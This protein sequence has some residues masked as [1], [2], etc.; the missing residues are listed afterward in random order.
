MPLDQSV[1]GTDTG[2]GKMLIT[3]SLLR[4]FAAAT[5][6]HDPVYIDVD[7]ARAAGHPDLPVPPTFFFSVDLESAD[8]AVYLADLGVDLRTVLHGEQEFIHHRMAHAGDELST[9]SRIVDVSS[10]KGGLLEFLRRETAVRGQDGAI[11]CVMR[12][13]LVVRNPPAAA[14]QEAR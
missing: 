13:V 4:R 2:G 14:C 11:V 10:K 1:I 3:R 7:A 9:T 5:G 6:Q 12:T 8:P